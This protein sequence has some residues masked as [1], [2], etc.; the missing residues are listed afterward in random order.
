M[1][2]LTSD[3]K[4]ERAQQA[5]ESRFATVELRLEALRKSGS[6][7]WL[8]LRDELD[9]AWEGLSHSIGRLVNRMKDASG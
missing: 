2:S 1:G 3:D 7:D 9:D 8:P 5:M 4:L 6:D